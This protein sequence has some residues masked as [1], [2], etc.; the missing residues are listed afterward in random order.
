MMISSFKDSLT[1]VFLTVVVSA[2]NLINELVIE[3]CK[4]LYKCL[5]LTTKNTTDLLKKKYN[6]KTCVVT[7]GSSGIGME[8]AKLLSSLGATVVISSRN[9]EKLEDVARQCKLMHPKALIFSIVLDLEKYEKI[10]HY[11][12]EI[13]DTLQRNGLPRRIDVLINNAGLSSRGMALDTDMGTLERL[14]VSLLNIILAVI[15]NMK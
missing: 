4:F 9:K 10:Q 15:C 1:Y 14:M 8:L 2:I 12:D 5:F 13:L 11:T 3:P 6:G 7:G